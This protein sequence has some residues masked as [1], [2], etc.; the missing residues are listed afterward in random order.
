MSRPLRIE[1]PG[2]VYHVMNRGNAFQSI[3]RSKDNYKSF[4]N[5]L[6][7]SVS[8]W[9]I[10]VHAFSL[11]PNHYHLLIETPLG[12]LS[13]AMRHINGVYTQRYNRR[14]KTDGHLFRGR[15]KAILV[16]E[17]AYFIEL[18]RYIHL[19]PVEAKLS[20]TPESHIWTS[21]RNYLRKE[22]LPWLTTSRLLM[23]FGKRK[24]IARQK[25]HEFVMC[26]I[27]EQLKKQLD[28]NRWPS[29]LS[30]ENFREWVE[31]NF[32]KNMDDKEVKYEHSAPMKL[33]KQRM[34]KIL[35]E[36]LDIKWKNLIKA[37]GREAKNKRRLAIR[38]LRKHQ[39]YSY[40][41]LS[42]LFGNMNA[43]NISRAINEELGNNEEIWEI[44]EL[45]I[46]NAKRK[47]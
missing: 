42:K 3:F 43:S 37:T 30:S 17:D 15:Y 27:P 22:E 16:E 35:C 47:T 18:L 26:G 7:E 39:K 1:Y 34:R 6:R 20:K 10:K 23:Y 12:N 46:K 40:G 38:S 21:H 14:W 33:N 45:E 44:L 36:V 8:L 32:V 11:M 5:I 31:W 4:L 19:N 25:L 13:R 29:V 28:G 9:E 24:N 41:E 2:A